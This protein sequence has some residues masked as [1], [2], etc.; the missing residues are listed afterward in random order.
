MIITIIVLLALIAFSANGFKAGSIETL[1]RVLGAVVGFI[2]AKS[3]VASVVGYVS[4]YISSDWAFLVSFLVIFLVVDSLVGWLFRLAEGLLKI[5]TRLPIL[6]QINSFLGL[7]LGFIEGIIVIGG[8]DWLLERSV[9]IASLSTFS[10]TAIV[11][12]IKLAFSVL[13][14]MLT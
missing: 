2:V 1:G 11:Q 4:H 7:I 9:K 8:A 13:F 12:W 6:K 3:L 5:F 14:G 10:N